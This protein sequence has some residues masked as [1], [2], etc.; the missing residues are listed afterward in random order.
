MTNNIQIFFLC[1]LVVFVTAM[2]I[3]G[4]VIGE[5]PLPLPSTAAPSYHPG[6]FTNGAA[7][8]EPSPIP[9]VVNTYEGTPDEFSYIPPSV[10]FSFFPGDGAKGEPPSIAGFVS[11]TL[12][13]V[14]VNI[15]GRGGQMEQFTYLATIY[16]DGRGIFVWKVPVWAQSLT[17]FVAEISQ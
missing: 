4:Q 5:Q 6:L 9:P 3:C 17:E 14:A 11:G 2:G 12:Q 1:S 7:P 13:N 8:P 16:P 10:S 15:S